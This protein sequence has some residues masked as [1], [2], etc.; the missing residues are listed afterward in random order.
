MSYPLL[1]LII[2]LIVIVPTVFVVR[3]RSNQNLLE[4]QQPTQKYLGNAGSATQNHGTKASAEQLQIANAINQYRNHPALP[5]SFRQLLGKIHSQY[6]ALASVKLDPEQRFTVDKLAGTRLSEIIEDYLALDTD[7]AENNIIDSQNNLTSQ[8]ITYGQLTSMLEF[9]Q[10]IQSDGQQQV[11]TNILANRSY[12]QSVYGE[13]HPDA[14]TND[15]LQSLKAPDMDLSELQDV[16]TSEL[17]IERG[18]SYLKDCDIMAPSELSLANHAAC[19]EQGILLQLGQLTFT[20]ENTI[21]Y[22]EALLGNSIDLSAF[23]KILTKALPQLLRRA[24]NET[25]SATLDVTSSV[26]KISSHHQA[27]LEQ[28]IDR[29]QQ[30]IDDC[31]NRLEKVAEQQYQTGSASPETLQSVNS[32]LKSKLSQAQYL[33][34]SGFFSL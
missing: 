2:S 14:P 27:L 31:L 10:R 1:L 23:D 17:L 16:P 25:N 28:K 4:N 13:F 26:N 5:I 11:A 6:L 8:D 12:L 18:Q 29:V 15:S 32:T 9:M 21:A 22:S 24:L 34:D 7:Y 20:A 30:L 33:L 3:G 19:F